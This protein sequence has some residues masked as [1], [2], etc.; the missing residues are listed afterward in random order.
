MPGRDVGP[1]ARRPNADYTSAEAALPSTLDDRKVRSPT[2]LVVTTPADTSP[3]GFA[4]DIPTRLLVFGMAHRDGQ[5]IGRELYD[6]IEPCG[7]SVDQMRSQM[8]RLVNEGIFERSGEGRDAVFRPTRNGIATMGSL[9]HRHRLA[10]AQDAAGR[11]WDRRWRLVAFAMPESRRADRDAL[12]D[13]LLQLGAAAVQNGL[14]AS[15]HRWDDEVRAEVDR[16]GVGDY[17]T[18]AVTEDLEIAGDRDPKH[19]ANALWPLEE[20]AERYRR[21]VASYEHVPETLDDMRRRGDRI[22]ESDY[23]PGALHIAIRFNE[24]FDRDPL[25]PPEL[26]PRPWPGRAARELLTRCRRLGMLTR[27]DRSGPALFDVFDETIARLP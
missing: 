10:Y 23:L 3:T 6:V 20:I 25:L 26:L 4:D 17:V 24:C 21:F 19:I 2:L 15:P 11:G 12:R 8:R 9:M 16:L 13:R 1:D 27:E 22:T 18:L 5:V 14:Y 7:V